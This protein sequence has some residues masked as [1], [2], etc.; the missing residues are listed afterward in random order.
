MADDFL[1]LTLVQL[2]VELQILVYEH[3]IFR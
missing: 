3:T 1:I 2:C